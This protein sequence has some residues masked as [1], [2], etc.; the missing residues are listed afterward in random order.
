MFHKQKIS[1]SS[2]FQ[3]FYVNGSA[4][5]PILKRERETKTYT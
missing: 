5:F 2:E 1:V 3:A 4:L